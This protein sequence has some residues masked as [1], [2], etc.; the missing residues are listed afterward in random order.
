M[1]YTAVLTV[2]ALLLLFA[3]VTIEVPVSSTDVVEILGAFV[4]MLV[5]FN[6]LLQR[7]LGPLERLTA[8]MRTIDPLAP[9]QRIDVGARAA[10][11]AALAEAFNGMLDRLEGERR[12]SARRALSAQES[13]R[14]RIARELHDEIGQLLTGIVL[15]SETLAR[16]VEDEL[17]PDLEDLREA[18][19]DAA[20]EAREIARRLRPEALDELGLQSA[21]LALCNAVSNGAG[22]EI[23]RDVE[24]VLPLTPEQELVIYRVAQESITNVV[25]HADARRIDVSL[26]RG[27]S[28]GVLLVV[29]DD[30]VGM[31]AGA[32]RGSN[33]IRG[34]RERALLVGADLEISASAR[35]GTEV[36]LH[37]PADE[38]A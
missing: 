31:P 37:L 19:R 15:R 25:R 30:G 24:R 18:A 16:R 22:I 28:G 1:A 7:L 10:E 5:V 9:G 32:E 13:E 14:R 35:G 12:E 2:A 6:F 38:V 4:V 17:R 8:L 26:T 11:V 23:A 36:R 21:L 27:A 20:E 34:M 29:S 33:G 3:P